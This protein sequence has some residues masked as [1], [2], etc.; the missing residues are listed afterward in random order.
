MSGEGREGEGPPQIFWPRAA[1]VSNADIVLRHVT[2]PLR[3]LATRELYGTPTFVVIT[4]LIKHNVKANLFLH[5]PQELVLRSPQ[6]RVRALYRI[7]RFDVD[8]TAAAA[9]ADNNVADVRDDYDDDVQLSTPDD[10]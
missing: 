8:S 7:Y 2:T 1:P 6:H 10:K 4:R 3:E 9:A 5:V